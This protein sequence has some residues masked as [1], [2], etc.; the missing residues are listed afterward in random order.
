MRAAAILVFFVTSFYT[1]TARADWWV[2]NNLPEAFTITVS[3]ARG[4]ASQVRVERNQKK[5]IR[6]GSD[7]H[8]IR[9][10]SNGG[11]V[12]RLQPT[13]LSDRQDADSPTELKTIL[14]PDGRDR[15][16]RRKYEYMNQD[17]FNEAD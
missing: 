11:N 2:Y 17:G 1:S 12:Y 13:H 8:K 5:A 3:P 9:L 16:G 7:R 14:T 10:R 4:N 6:L 15:N